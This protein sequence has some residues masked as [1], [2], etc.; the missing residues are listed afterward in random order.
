MKPDGQPSG[1]QEIHPLKMPRA[2]N[3]IAR[4]GVPTAIIVA[5]HRVAIEEVVDMWIIDEE[6]WRDLISRQY[7]AIRLDDGRPMT[8]FRDRV[9]DRWYEQ[10]V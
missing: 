8:I 6:W 4:D 7:F 9:H 1:D 5:G 2:L 10:D 3:A